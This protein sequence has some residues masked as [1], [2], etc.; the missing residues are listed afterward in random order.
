MQDFSENLQDID[1]NEA[2]E[3]EDQNESE[4]EEDQID[5][6]DEMGDVDEADDKQVDP[7]LWDENE[8]KQDSKDK[9]ID[10]E[11]QGRIFL[12]WKL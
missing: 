3:D 11:Q 12:F 1:K 8:E 9:N 5:P 7:K 6:E 10:D 4:N 2:A